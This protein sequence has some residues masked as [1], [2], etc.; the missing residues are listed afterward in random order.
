MKPNLGPLSIQTIIWDQV[1]CSVKSVVELE[2][3]P[4]THRMLK[5]RTRAANSSHDRWGQ[6]HEASPA[7]RTS[8]KSS[9]EVEIL[10]K[11][12]QKLPPLIPYGSLRLTWHAQRPDDNRQ[13]G[14]PRF[15]TGD[16]QKRHSFTTFKASL[17]PHKELS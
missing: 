12:K 6:V 13:K 17:Q 8:R 1:N 3:P 15:C 4:A 9:D 11:W 7:L 2:A 10:A 14:C 16:P 5:A